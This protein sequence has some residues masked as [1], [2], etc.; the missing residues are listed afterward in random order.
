LAKGSKVA[1]DF[2]TDQFGLDK[3]PDVAPAVL[4]T[5]G[6]IQ[7]AG[8]SKTGAFYEPKTTA[9]KFAGAVGE[10][11]GNP[12][13]YIGPGGV[14]GKVT[15]A[16]ATGVGSEAAGEAAQEYAPEWEGTARFAG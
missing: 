2:I 10:T 8:E 11:V 6:G 7:K 13:S 9:G 12:M 4:P 1:S 5:S 3:G 14:L 15:G 16:T